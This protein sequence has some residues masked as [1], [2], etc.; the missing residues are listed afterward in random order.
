VHVEKIVINGEGKGEDADRAAPGSE[1][2]LI[3]LSGSKQVAYR[4][5]DRFILAN[6]DE[7]QRFVGYGLVP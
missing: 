3:T 2:I 4:G 6:L 1:R 5:T 7:K